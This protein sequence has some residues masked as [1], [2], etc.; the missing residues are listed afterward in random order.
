MHIMHIYDPVTACRY[1]WFN[2]MTSSHVASID[3]AAPFP[4]ADS[5]GDG[6][7]DGNAD[8]GAYRQLACQE[9][10]QQ[11]QSSLSS[12]SLPFC[13]LHHLDMG[14]RLHVTGSL[15]PGGLHALADG[16]ALIALY[17]QVIR[18]RVVRSDQGQG[19]TR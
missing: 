4:T 10:W 5:N 14:F 8:G 1:V 9:P 15:R 3:T 2:S 11:Q 18:S 13:Q 6:D 7:G 12:S 16:S 19:Q 17:S